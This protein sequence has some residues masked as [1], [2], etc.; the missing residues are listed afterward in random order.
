MGFIKTTDHRPTYHR[1]NNPPT[2]QPTDHF[3]LTHRPRDQSSST[4]VK[5]EDQILNMFCNL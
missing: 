3:P 5:T 2:H 1:P 4:Y